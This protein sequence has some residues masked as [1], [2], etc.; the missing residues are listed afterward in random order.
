MSIDYVVLKAELAASHPVSGAYNANDQLAA[1]QLNL[2]NIEINKDTTP[3]E[4]ADATDSAEFN[5]LTDADQQKWISVL[6][7]ETLNLNSGIGL[8]TAQG[9]W[10]TGGTPNTKAA[11]LASRR[12]DV[13]RTSQLNFGRQAINASQVAHARAL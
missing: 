1:D 5:V 11:L 6:S 2:E 9:M 10:N 7:W 8:A 12:V 3:V 13:S 4:A